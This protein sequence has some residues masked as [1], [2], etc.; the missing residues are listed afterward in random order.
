MDTLDDYLANKL[1]V[2]SGY[3]LNWSPIRVVFMGKAIVQANLR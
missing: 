3:L 2:I 1:Q